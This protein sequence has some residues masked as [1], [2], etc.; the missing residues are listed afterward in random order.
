[1]KDATSQRA[2][3]A[4]A[5]GEEGD[6][7]VECGGEEEDEQ[8]EQHEPQVLEVPPPK[9]AM[10]KKESGKKKAAFMIIGPAKG[11]QRA[12]SA[13]PTQREQGTTSTTF[14]HNWE[15]AKQQRHKIVGCSAAQMRHH[16]R[17]CLNKTGPLCVDESGNLFVGEAAKVYSGGL[18][19]SFAWAASVC[20]AHQA[21]EAPLR[22]TGPSWKYLQMWWH[23]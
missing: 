15:R 18:R 16:H 4:A 14:L 8:E 23:R 21:V 7:E 12:I 9:S 17:H 13:R 5:A 3:A 20:P 2:Q 11:G 10:T 19:E 22:S 1:M 6:E